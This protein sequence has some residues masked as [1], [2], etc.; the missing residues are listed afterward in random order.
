[1]HHIQNT[2]P[3]VHQ[4]LQAQSMSTLHSAPAQ[5]EVERCLGHEVSNSCSAKSMQYSCSRTKQE[6]TQWYSRTFGTLTLQKKS[7]YSKSP[8]ASTEGKAPLISET[9]WTFRPSFISYALQLRY[10]RSFGYISRSLNI[11]PVL[12]RHDR[13]FEMCRNGEL[14]GLQAALSRQGVSPFVTDADG[15]SLLHVSREFHQHLIR[16]CILIG[17]STLQLPTDWRYATGYC[18]WV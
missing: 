13:V 8:N 2:V 5:N 11:Y 12:S 6:H 18:R 4:S 15:W 10:A 1:M 14:L 9:A 7:K 17:F 3:I 16:D